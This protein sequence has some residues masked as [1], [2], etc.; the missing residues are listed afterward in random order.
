[1]SPERP[2]AR[3]LQVLP[4]VSIDDGMATVHDV[5]DCVYRSTKDY[6]VRHED[7]T[8]DLSRLETIDFFVE[9]MGYRTLAHTF[10]SFG[11]QGDYLNVSVEIRR[12]TG[13]RFSPWKGLFKNFEITY[14]VADEKDSVLVRTNHRKRD[15]YRY[16]IKTTTERMQRMFESVAGRV[17][18]LHA[19]PEF[20]NTVF[21][22]CTTSIARHVNV[23]NPGKVPLSTKLV[24][25]GYSD[26]LAHRIGLI[27]TDLSYGEARKQAFI[28]EKAQAAGDDPDFSRII[29]G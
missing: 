11:F 15:V 14:V 16:P 23:V 19:Q 24:F 22:N 26:K 17:N 7:R 20:Y 4:R 1:M 12:K 18:Q 27:D 29:R 8:Y 28:T 6:D 25:T 13:D 2:W 21:N 9:N 10:L 3:D 5:R